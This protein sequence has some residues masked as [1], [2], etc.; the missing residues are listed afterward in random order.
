MIE[1]MDSNIAK[2]IASR[3]TEK[4]KKE[5]KPESNKAIGVIHNSDN[6]NIRLGKI[7]HCHIE[8]DADDVV[9]T[10]PDDGTRDHFEMRLVFP[11]KEVLKVL[12]ALY[13][14]K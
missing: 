7:M 14:N 3:N 6:A 10:L 1:P 2:L 4:E 9:I 5:E 8:T 11:K 13:T 12:G